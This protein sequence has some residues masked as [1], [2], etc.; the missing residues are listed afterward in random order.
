MTNA[1]TNEPTKHE[2][3]RQCTGRL[4]PKSLWGDF[5]AAAYFFDSLYEPTLGRQ[6]LWCEIRPEPTWNAKPE[7]QQP[8]D[9]CRR[10]VPLGDSG[11][12]ERIANEVRLIDAAV[13]R[14]LSR[15]S[16]LY[17][18][19][20]YGVNPRQFGDGTKDGVLGF[21]AAYADL[22]LVKGGIEV[23]S[24]IE[25]LSLLALPPSALIWSGNGLHVYW[26]FDEFV[27][28]LDRDRVEALNWGIANRLK[29]L[30]PD[31]AVRDVSRILR[32]PMTRN[33]KAG[34][35]GK[36]IHLM[37]C[38]PERRYSLLRLERYF[39]GPPTVDTVRLPSGT[40]RHDGQLPDF[41][42]G[43]SWHNSVRGHLVRL[44]SLGVPEDQIRRRAAELAPLGKRKGAEKEV[45]RMADWV[46]KNIDPDVRRIGRP[47]RRRR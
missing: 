36:P 8:A 41:H 11:Q 4:L 31:Y 27:A 13:S 24:A 15:R 3:L 39:P 6:E 18:Q 47:P 22:E 25:Q 44:A 10:W 33:R 30:H 1:T 17:G 34:Q 20:Y 19:T 7:R 2:R 35:E 43:P 12:G 45:I 23:Q 16:G 5:E 37:A 21:V 42:M 14:R 38:M 28:P 9:P 29:R 46:S 26:F 40:V 32:P